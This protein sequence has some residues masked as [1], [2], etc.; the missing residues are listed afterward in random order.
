LN[1]FIYFASY[2]AIHADPFSDEVHMNPVRSGH[3]SHL[4]TIPERWNRM[5]HALHFWRN[6]ND[7]PTNRKSRG[8]ENATALFGCGG[9]IWTTDLQVMPTTTVFT[10]FALKAKFV[11]WTIP[12]PFQQRTKWRGCLPSS[13]YT[14]Q[15]LKNIRCSAWLGI[16][17]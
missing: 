15:T 12:S 8:V 14:F 10:A 7:A 2:Y 3:D 1:L 17:I 5:R 6:S 9:W 4:S 16:T 13:L 11:V